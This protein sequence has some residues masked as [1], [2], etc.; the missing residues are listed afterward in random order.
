M[1]SDPDGVFCSSDEALSFSLV[2]RFL[3]DT[4]VTG[5]AVSSSGQAMVVSTEDGLIRRSNSLEWE[6]LIIS[7]PGSCPTLTFA[8]G[9]EAVLFGL[10]VTPALPGLGLEDAETALV[11]RLDLNQG[12]V[13]TVEALPSDVE[14][15][16]LALDPDF[17]SVVYVATRRHGVYRSQDGGVTFEA[18][19]TGISAGVPVGGL[20]REGTSL[21]VIGSPKRLVFATHGGGVYYREVGAGCNAPSLP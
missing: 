9:S 4:R 12:V 7:L 19:N 20:I 15:V 18:W 13:E 1:G 3:G 17:S 16:A 10:C 2:A 8:A 21:S 11:V 6:S 14:P 5:L